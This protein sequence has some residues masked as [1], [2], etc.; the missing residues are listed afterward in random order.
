MQYVVNQPSRAIELHYSDSCD[1][2][3]AISATRLK[4]KL[5]EIAA[6]AGVSRIS[7]IGHLDTLG[8]AVWQAV[9]PKS[10]TLIVS[11][12]KGLSTA[13]AI[14][15]AILEAAELAA[16]EAAPWHIRATPHELSR[17]LPYSVRQLPGVPEYHPGWD[18]RIEW[19]SAEILQTGEQTLV[20][21]SLIRLDFTTE[22][23]GPFFVRATSTG[24]GTGL[25]LEAATEHALLEVIEREANYRNRF[26]EVAIP[27]LAKK[28]P[29]LGRLVESWASRGTRVKI[30]TCLNSLGV[31]VA[32]AK[33]SDDWVPT[34]SGSCAHF[35]AT[36]AAFRAVLEAG[37][38]RATILSGSRDDIE[39]AHFAATPEHTGAM[40]PRVSASA[41]LEGLRPCGSTT[42]LV[43]RMNESRH[44]ILRVH[45]RKAPVHV[46]RVVVTGTSGP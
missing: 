38:S 31:H 24:T 41:T 44:V 37:Q 42:E 6:E 35:D 22:A 25:S 4:S 3:R 23:P 7:D 11:Q 8:L 15:G 45:L 2:T 19:T 13:D 34:V 18:K 14:T 30:Q 33:I 17:R 21:T 29:V 12:G 16:A 40:E 26:S 43:Q 39:D 46:V 28:L 20:P 27:S 10:R 32:V 5:A 1:P 36:L 9:R